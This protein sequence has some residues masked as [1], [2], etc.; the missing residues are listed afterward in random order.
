V[1]AGSTTDQDAAEIPGRGFWIGLGLGTPVMVYG[2]VELV[3]KT[4]WSR[5][6]GVARW[7][8]GGVLLHDLVLVPIVLAIVWAIGRWTPAAAHTPLRVAVLGSALVV[9]IGWPGLRGYGNKPDNATIHPLDYGTAVVTLLALLWG[10]A[11]VWAAWRLARREPR[12]SGRA[13]SAAGQ[14]SPRTSRTR[15]SD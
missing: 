14:D 7:F 11:L 13:P 8:G 2:A 9:A 1:S 12:P 6:L 10:A 4:G 5:S 3:R 15:A